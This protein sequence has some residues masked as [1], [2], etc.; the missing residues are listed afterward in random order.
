[1]TTEDKG[2]W[3]DP[4][5]DINYRVDSGPQ[6]RDKNRLVIDITAVFRSIRALFKKVKK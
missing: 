1:V 2:G 3:R 6:P 5:D 4:V